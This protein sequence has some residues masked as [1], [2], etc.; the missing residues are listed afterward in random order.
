M[1]RVIN[2][3]LSALMAQAAG[4]GAFAD[5]IGVWAGFPQPLDRPYRVRR[6]R[7][8]SHKQNRRRAMR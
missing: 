6:G 3:L 4:W 8:G 2:M 1:S 5:S 7:K